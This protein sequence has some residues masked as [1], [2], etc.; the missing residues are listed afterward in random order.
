MG[1]GPILMICRRCRRNLPW[2]IPENQHRLPGYG[3]DLPIG[4]S[5]FSVTLS[6]RHI[7]LALW[8]L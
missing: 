7:S 8:R 6:P 1:E 3:T 4:A 2:C 5:H